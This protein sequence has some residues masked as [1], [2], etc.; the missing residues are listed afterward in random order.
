MGVSIGV[1]SQ[2][3]PQ[4][5]LWRDMQTVVWALCTPAVRRA[6]AEPS[7][8]VVFVGSDLGKA[9]SSSTAIPITADA[10]SN[11]LSALTRQP[12]IARGTFSQFASK[13]DVAVFFETPA[14]GLFDELHRQKKRVVYV[15]NL[16]WAVLGSTA[17]W[18]RAIEAR[19]WIELWARQP[20]I[21]KRLREI[22]RSTANRVIEIPWSIPDVVR[23][24]VSS[25]QKNTVGLYANIGNGGFNGRRAL[26]ETLRAFAAAR[27]KEPRLR[28]TIKTVKAI[29]PRLGL[30]L[31]N[32]A[33]RVGFEPRGVVEKTLRDAD[34]VVHV[35]R[36]EGF[37][38]PAIEAL[39]AGK[40]VLTH[41]GWPVGDLVEHHHD[42]LVVG[43]KHS[44]SMN[45]TPIWRV[46][47]TALANAMVAIAN[48][49]LRG[50]LTA[51][52]P[53]ELVARQHAFRLILRQRLLRERPADVLV[54]SAPSI[55][56]GPRRSEQYW[57]DGLAAHGYTV[58]K[59]SW[60][61]LEDTLLRRSFDAIFAGK[62]PIVHLE[63]IRQKSTSPIAVWHHDHY[64][65]V[66]MRGWENRVLPLVDL[67]A[68][69]QIIAGPKRAYVLPGPRS[70]GS[71]GY[72]HRPHFHPTKNERS[73]VVFIGNRCMQGKR[74]PLLDVI[75]KQTPI[76]VYG[77][78]Q[79]RAPVYDAAADSV[80]RSA[81][82]ALSINQLE[83]RGYTSNRMFHACANGACVVAPEFEQS[84]KAAPRGVVLVKNDATSIANTIRSLEKSGR[85]REH[86]Q[87]SERN[88]W[89]HHTWTDRV[90]KILVLLRRVKR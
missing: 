76:K 74:I 15:P 77:I 11:G 81:R 59:R 34:A 29:D 1:V 49:A 12:E 17:S 64:A 63:R 10:I 45:L 47:E 79:P 48:D 18:I 37:G 4:K 83:A 87:Q 51:P 6:G 36:W 50:R 73:G 19:P 8:V 65:M 60:D 7:R 13:V 14:L 62:I 61:Q 23:R 82:I 3:V 25:T 67:Y 68:E 33:V 88:M 53:S 38:Y 27:K 42:G 69:P 55:P 31:T 44:G 54:I 5:G 2:N 40:P 35:S 80:Y 32:V 9:S 89:R 58:V 30:D 86:A 57:A 16:D 28:L 56:G 90:S 26:E 52:E 43:A 85:W 72:G 24:D 46:D 84:D 39:H 41:N 66:R 71:R 20:S 78:N 70:A 75:A 21:A 22:L